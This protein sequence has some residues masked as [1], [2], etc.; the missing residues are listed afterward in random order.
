M[1]RLH[2]LIHAGMHGTA[3][4]SE[5]HNP[6]RLMM[7]MQ[8]P[9]NCAASSITQQHTSYCN[10]AAG[11]LGNTQNEKPAPPRSNIPISHQLTHTKSHSE[12]HSSTRLVMEMWHPS[13]CAASS[14]TQQN[15]SYCNYAAGHLG[16]THK[17]QSLQRLAQIF[18]S[19]R[20]SANTHQI[21]QRNT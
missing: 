21:T 8:H 12:T 17:M 16:D 4:H 2:H 9:S 3:K 7:E 10:Y 6:T 13:N 1:H 15:T 14:I 18:Y 5:T 19:N 20:S 11:T